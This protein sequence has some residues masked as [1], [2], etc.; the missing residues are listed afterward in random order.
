[1]PAV[2]FLSIHPIGGLPGTL[3][4]V[5]TATRSLDLAMDVYDIAADRKWARTQQEANSAADAPYSTVK[6]ECGV[7]VV[8]GI[9]SKKASQ[10]AV[11]R[12]EFNEVEKALTARLRTLLTRPREL[13]AHPHMTTARISR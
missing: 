11:Q 2:A 12:R 1:M 9:G 7:I 5:E 10:A 3:Q 6:A 4:D 13:R 8:S